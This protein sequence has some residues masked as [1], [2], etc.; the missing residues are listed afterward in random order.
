MANTAACRILVISSTVDTAHLFVQRSYVVSLS[1]LHKLITHSPTHLHIYTGIQALSNPLEDAP[2][3]SSQVVSQSPSAEGL[4]ELHASLTN[5]EP[6]VSIPWTI[7][8]KYY[9]ADV[10]FELRQ[11]HDFAGYLASEVPAVVFVWNQGEEYMA[12]ISE[13]STK[14]EHYDPEV[15]LAVRFASVSD[16]ARKDEQGEDRVDEFISS[17]GFEYVDGERG[18]RVPTQ[19]GSSFSDEE[20]TGAAYLLIVYN[21]EHD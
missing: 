3:S 13:L 14:L 10:H 12:N 1:W 15:S 19:D 8:N 5:S 17:H 9:T 2:H 21:T 7:S 11:L 6:A 18:R 4:G 16:Q 20:H